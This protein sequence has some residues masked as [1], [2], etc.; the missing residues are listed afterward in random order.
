MS[1]GS[2][3]A[4]RQR[5][6]LEEAYQREAI[7]KAHA[8]DLL[9]E[10]VDRRN[11]AF[12]RAFTSAKQA[13][14]ELDRYLHANSRVEL[15]EQKAR[16]LAQ[17]VE[18]QAAVRELFDRHRR[19]LH[20]DFVAKFDSVEDDLAEKEDRLTDALSA[21]DL[22]D[23]CDESADEREWLNSGDEAL[24]TRWM[25]GEAP[26]VGAGFTA[27]LRSPIRPRS[28]GTG[29][30]AQKTAGARSPD[31]YIRPASRRAE[32][33]AGAARHRPDG[34]SGQR[35]ARPR[36]SPPQGPS[37]PDSPWPPGVGRPRAGSSDG[38][39]RATP[40]P[41]TSP[42]SPTW[43]GGMPPLSD[44]ELSVYTGIPTMNGPIYPDA[45]RDA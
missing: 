15:V 38:P 26:R 40:S 2:R 28:G 3:S 24:L 39:G 11:P 4:R 22:D 43:L 7:F 45:T 42:G 21:L 27:E 16:T 10:G 44:A 41:P 13:S 31:P 14:A 19:F 34:G 20:P 30:L 17:R 29:E 1:R 25:L 5:L 12:V 9:R 18:A 6:Q 8:L 23:A 32:T 35:P 36:A 33:S 37:D